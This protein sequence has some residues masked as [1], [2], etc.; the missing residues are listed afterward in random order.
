MA[1]DLDMLVD[2]GLDLSDSDFEDAEPGP[3]SSE[4]GSLGGRGDAESSSGRCSSS[5]D[6]EMESSG[7]EEGGGAARGAAAAR[8]ETPPRP[9]ADARRGAPRAGA[10]ATD[11]WAHLGRRRRRSEVEGP[12]G[13][14]ARGDRR[15]DDGEAPSPR[16]RRRPRSAV[17]LVKT[18]GPGAAAPPSP[19]SARGSRRRGRRGRGRRREG[20][21]PRPTAPPGPGHNAAET[22]SHR[23]GRAA[24]P[25]LMALAVAPPDTPAEREG[26]GRGGRRGA[27]PPENI[28]QRVRAVLR[29]ISERA[30]AERVSETFGRSAAAMHHP[31]GGTQFAAPD[32]PWAPVLGSS[33]G[34]YNPEQRRVSWETLAA[35]GPGLY[36]TFVT[37]A[38]A[39]VVARTLRE[40]VLRQEGFVEA[41]ASADELLSWCKMCVHHGLPL[42]PQ[43]PIIATA[44][45][46]L[47]NLS[48]RLRPFLQCYFKAR[49][50]LPLDELCARRRL[51][52]IREIASFVFVTLAR[53][54]NGAKHRTT[55]IEH[56]AVGVAP[57]EKMDFYVP[58]ACMA[59]LIEILDTHRQECSSRTCELTASHIIAPLYVHGKYF[60]CNSLF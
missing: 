13:G 22:G 55:E 42:R 16:R 26:P 11:V 23:D 60:Y 52:D 46:V 15:Y 18:F 51:S 43:D 21:R 8:A 56:A 39:A 14:D 30:A 4:P 45:A 3:A 34:G 19:S 59:G 6:E 9:D 38:R 2:L 24:P 40:C 57:G 50:V 36:R 58:G 17:A 35:H 10:P 27:A 7:E 28:D 41:V 1:A 29:S 12:D 49:G 5:D 47:E 48:T 32:S 54:A 33:V 25:S 44:G 20:G 53:L 31:F 37:N